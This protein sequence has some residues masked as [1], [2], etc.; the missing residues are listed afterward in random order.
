MENKLSALHELYAR[1]TGACCEVVPKLSRVFVVMAA[2]CYVIGQIDKRHGWESF[3]GGA[4]N[5]KLLLV[6]GCSRRV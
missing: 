3:A 6:G 1:S 2:V 4:S 5:D